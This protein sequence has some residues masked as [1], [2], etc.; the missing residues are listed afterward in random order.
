MHANIARSMKQIFLLCRHQKNG[1]DEVVSWIQKIYFDQLDF[2]RNYFPDFPRLTV[3]DRADLI[4]WDYIPPTPFS[5]HNFWGHFIYGI[6]EYPI[7]SVLQNGQ[8]LMK[9][10]MIEREDVIRKNIFKQGERLFK[11]FQMSSD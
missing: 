8:F 1:P 10:R 4:L 5:I 9:N 2:I 3:G 7:H 11:K 6:L